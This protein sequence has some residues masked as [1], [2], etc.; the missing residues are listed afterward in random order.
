MSISQIVTQ[1][2]NSLYANEFKSLS[3]NFVMLREKLNLLQTSLDSLVSRIEILEAIKNTTTNDVVVTF[4]PTESV[5]ESSSF[6]NA[7]EDLAAEEQL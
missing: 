5:Q 2:R 3:D 4:A 6:Q 7:E 1:V